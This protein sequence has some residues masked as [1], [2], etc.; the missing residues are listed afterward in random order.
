M[1]NLIMT[2]A[3]SAAIV[4]A[5]FALSSPAAAKAKAKAKQQR[6]QPPEGTITGRFDFGPAPGP[7]AAEKRAKAEL[8]A[9]S[10]EGEYYLDETTDT[11]GA[12]LSIPTSGEVAGRLA[13]R[14]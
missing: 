9:F 13:A 4:A 8:P 6:Q 10:H 1:R 2:I 11:G 7:T 5:L 14:G 12:I 3:T